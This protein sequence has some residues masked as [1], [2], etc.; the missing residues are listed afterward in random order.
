MFLY[1]ILVMKLES[2]RCPRCGYT[3]AKFHWDSSTKYGDIAWRDIGLGVNGRPDGRSK[4]IM[5]L[6]A[7]CWRQM[8]KN[9]T[10]CQ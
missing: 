7:Y 4:S 10:Q 5:P 9:V 2:I 6:D 3:C 1:S 8:Y